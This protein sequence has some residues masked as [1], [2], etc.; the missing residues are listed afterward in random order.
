MDGMTLLRL[1]DC[2]ISTR[3]GLADQWPGAE[4]RRLDALGF[5]QAFGAG[6]QVT[7][8]GFAFL[9]LPDTKDRLAR[10]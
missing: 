7:A 5:T 6:R 3:F 1:R 4:M 10:L 2:A 9:A 8:S